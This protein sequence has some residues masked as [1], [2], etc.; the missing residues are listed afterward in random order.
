MTKQK[1]KAPVKAPEVKV[2]APKKVQSFERR[3][4][5]GATMAISLKLAEAKFKRVRAL[6]SKSSVL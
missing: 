6:T 2:E 1:V 4:K 3:D 5:S